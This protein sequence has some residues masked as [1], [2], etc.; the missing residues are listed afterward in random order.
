MPLRSGTAGGEI[1]M[2]DTIGEKSITIDSSAQ[3]IYGYICDFS[4]HAEWNHQ[5]TEI[6]KT[7]EGPIGV[8]STF[9]TREQIHGVAPWYMKVLMRVMPP[10]YTE[11]EITA[12]EP[13]RRLAW[14]A[15]LPTRSGYS[16]KADWEILLDP[17]DEATKVTQ[18]YH[19]MPQTKLGDRMGAKGFARMIGREVAANLEILKS[20][21]E[22]HTR[23]R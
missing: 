4:R 20:T 15:A 12:M 18:R 10:T 1:I 11:A 22:G 6:I 23:D 14:N 16:M 17:R 9:R 8:G 2:P 13:G 21:V 7:S 5:P 3:E 19:Y